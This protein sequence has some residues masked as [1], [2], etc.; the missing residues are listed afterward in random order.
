MPYATVTDLAALGVSAEATEETETAA[1]NAALDSASS[2]ADSYLA[3]VYTLPLTSW[4]GAL[5]M[6]V[7]A[8]AA[9]AVM[10]AR[11]FDPSGSDDVL[12]QRRQDALDWLRMLADGELAPPDIVDSTPDTK[13]GGA[14]VVTRPKRGW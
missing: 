10:A 5:R 14:A 13:E 2:E 7:A 8:I 4:G 9:Y 3:K 1:L 6:H 11:G 12:R